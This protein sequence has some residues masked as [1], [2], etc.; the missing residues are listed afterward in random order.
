MSETIVPNA[1]EAHAPK[2]FG[3]KDWWKI[4]FIVLLISTVVSATLAV[5]F[6]LNMSALSEELEIVKGQRTQVEE[7]LA[8]L[9]VENRDLSESK[10]PLFY[11][12]RSDD[13]QTS[14]LVAVDPV[15]KVENDIYT[16]SQFLEIVGA[17]HNAL[18]TLILAISA[19]N[20]TGNKRIL[21]FNTETGTVSS[22][23]IF[24]GEGSSLSPNLQIGAVVSFVDSE[25]Q[26][27][28]TITGTK[29]VGAKLA[30]G[31]YFDANTTPFAVG[32]MEQIWID[33]SCVL[34]NVY[35]DHNDPARDANEKVLKERR[36]VCKE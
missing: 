21:L 4:G 15:T 30:E 34:V 1:L 29:T 11:I 27:I 25:L 26:F 3:A 20:G 33:N 2:K 24:L 16:S 22:S 12:R 28:E 18:N 17:P 10:R 14:V 6:G 36:K 8:G 19:D 5:V 13:L 7:R 23:T 35:V 31:E 32:G 9:V